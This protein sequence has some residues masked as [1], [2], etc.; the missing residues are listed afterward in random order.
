VS[1]KV[2]LPFFLTTSMALAQT[3]PL[4]SVDLARAAEIQHLIETRGPTVWLG[5]KPAPLLLCKGDSDYLIGHSSPPFGFVPISPSLYQ[6]RGHLVPMPAATAW[7]VGNQWSLAL[8]SLEEFQQAINRVLGVGVIQLS[9]S[10]YIAAAVHEA[11]HAFQM[12]T[13]AGQPSRFGFRGDDQKTLAQIQGRAEALEAE[14]RVLQEALVATD[15]IAMQREVSRFLALRQTRRN[16][17]GLEAASLEQSL[18]WLEGMARY[19]DV[20]LMRLVTGQKS[21]DG[22]FEYPD[23]VWTTFLEQLGNLSS[24]PGSLR[25]WYYLLG[26]AQGFVLDKLLP[27]WKAQVLPKGQSLEELLKT[28]SAYW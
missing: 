12:Q 2:W 13:T 8:P 17:L 22:R 28:Q 21:Q 6:R 7:L 10:S 9:E 19:A 24:V 26:A 27:N 25:D 11:F 15:L 23:G 20:S 16:Q 18:E 14:G 3:V 5:W 1:L 4:S